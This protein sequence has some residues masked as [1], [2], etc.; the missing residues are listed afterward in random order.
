MSWL[1]LLMQNNLEALKSARQA[2]K[3]NNQDPQARMN[4]ALALLATNT[5]GVREHIELIKRMMIMMPE[6]EDEIK[7]SIEDGF[8]RYPDWPELKKIQKWLA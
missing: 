5:K 6:L 2:V 8:E 4:L 1:Y 3:L 7:E